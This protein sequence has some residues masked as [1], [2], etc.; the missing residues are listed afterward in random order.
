MA[1][2][3]GRC[4]SNACD[5]PSELLVHRGDFAEVG[6]VAIPAGERLR[7][8]VRRVRIE[9]VHPHELRLRPLVAQV[10]DRAVGRRH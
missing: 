1:R 6:L 4:C 2:G 8:G 7:R 5:E 3:S 9:V 10:L